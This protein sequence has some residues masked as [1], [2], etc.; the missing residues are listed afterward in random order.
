MSNEIN[1][2]VADLGACPRMK[3]LLRKIHFGHIW[4]KFSLNRTTIRLKFTPNLPQ[5][6][7]PLLRLPFSDKLLAAY[8]NGTLHGVWIDA[9]DDL[10]N[11]WDQINKML[12]DSPEEN[13]EEY[14]IHDYEGFEG[15]SIGEYEGIE[16][17]HNVA[18][19]LE[20][21]EGYGGDFLSIFNGNI[22][23][24]RKAAEESYSGCYK[25]FP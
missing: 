23:E 6:G 10:D 8:N 17:A 16:N 12:A 4:C 15:Y 11:I 14:A 25:S 3:S 20:E 18:C 1:I 7:F 22:E 19:F 9:A 5:N 21:F 2:Y 24:A 13:A